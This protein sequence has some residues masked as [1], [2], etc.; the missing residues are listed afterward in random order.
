MNFTETVRL[1]I[2]HY[3]YLVLVVGV[4]AENTGVPLPGEVLIVL[5]AY[6]AADL[7]LS[8]SLKNGEIK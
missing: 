6:M 1:L 2:G 7:N 4:L 5:T 3:G 8:R